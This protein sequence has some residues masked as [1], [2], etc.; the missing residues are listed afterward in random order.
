MPITKIQ[1]VCQMFKSYLLIV[2]IQEDDYMGRWKS[3]WIML[4]MDGNNGEKPKRFTEMQNEE[5]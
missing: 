1:I 4:A 3:L 5:S 2:Q